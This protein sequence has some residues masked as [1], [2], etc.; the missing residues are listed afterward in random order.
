[1][2]A[3]GISRKKENVMKRHL[4]PFLLV[5]LLAAC[6]SPALPNAPATAIPTSTEIPPT[7]TLAPTSTIT[8][9]PTT[10]PTE[11]P[12]PTDT[13]AAT[14]T[15]DFVIMS[16]N[17]MMF[18]GIVPA[19]L[20]DA[21]LTEACGAPTF[22]NAIAGRGDPSKEYFYLTDSHPLDVYQFYM[23]EMPKQ[24]WE[25]IRISDDFF[26]NIPLSSAD[27]DQF[28]SSIWFQNSSGQTA[29]ITIL[30]DFNN[31]QIYVWMLCSS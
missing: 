23:T 2:T 28:H 18:E 21:P 9:T 14:P 15:Y 26:G 30:K 29:T 3:L 11:T 17:D 10:A 25:L 13:P 27:L 1:V 5:T 22:T 4:F 31:G 20:T 7:E 19:D 16:R 8:Q 12:A 6:A 24:N